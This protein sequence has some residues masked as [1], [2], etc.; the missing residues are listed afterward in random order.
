MMSVEKTLKAY[1]EEKLNCAQSLLRGFQESFKVSEAIVAEAE[2]WGGG[3][4]EGGICGALYSACRLTSDEEVREILRGRFLSEAG[5]D[6]CREIRK[7]G[8]LSCGGCVELAAKVLHA[9]NPKKHETP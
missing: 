2:K 1:R 3:R 4:A 9:T 7:L 8:R 5:S 6:R